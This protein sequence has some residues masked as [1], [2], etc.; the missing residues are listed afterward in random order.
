MM[1]FKMKNEKLK[2]RGMT[3]FIA[4]TI[5]GILLLVS[6]AIINISIK[7]SQFATSGRDSQFA[8]YAADAGLECAVY[9]D[10]KTTSP[11]NIGSSATWAEVHL[12]EFSGI[13]DVNPLDV[14]AS[15]SQT[16]NSLNVSIT[17]GTALTT[18]NND[19]LFGYT[20]QWFFGTANVV[21]TGGFIEIADDFTDSV[22]YKNVTSIGNHAATFTMANPSR[23]NG[24]WGAIMVA[25]KAEPS[26]TPAFVQHNAGDGSIGSTQAISFLNPSVSGNTI[27]MAFQYDTFDFTIESITD[28]KGNI[29]ER[30]LD[31]LMYL[32][33]TEPRTQEVWYANN[34]IG[35]GS[36]IEITVN[37][38]AFIPID[39]DCN[40]QHITAGLGSSNDVQTSPP[41][42]HRIGGGGLANP[43]SIFQL[44]FPDNTCAIVTV[45]KDPSLPTYIQ[46]K[47][48]NTCS[49]SNPRRVE[50]GIE[51]DY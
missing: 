5:M 51:V 26:E 23:I 46:S 10:S 3:L 24:V 43:T 40:G 32:D 18:N 34:I 37:S 30:A 9:W 28:N 29:Y 19:L 22:A 45:R 14:S 36:P 7:G 42:P 16:S 8:F 41:Q 2:N 50:R 35:G 21:P 39:I 6:F 12:T 49:S 20:D 17:S 11:F 15:R 13:S 48:Y 25:F 1:N 27:V 4:V 31:P 47:G 33:G 44:N 38:Q